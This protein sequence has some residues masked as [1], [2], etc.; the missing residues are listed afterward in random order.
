MKYFKTVQK[1]TDVM[2]FG[3]TRLHE[4]DNIPNQ[5]GYHPFEHVD[6]KTELGGVGFYIAE[7]IDYFVRNDLSME[8]DRVEDLWIEID[9]SKNIENLPK[10]SSEKYVIGNIYRHPGS[11]YK[12][13]CEKLCN[14]LETLNKSKTKYI[15]LGDYNIDMLKYNLATNVSNYANSLNSVGCNIHVDKPTRVEKN[16]AT[17]IDHVYSNLSPDRLSNRIVMS[18]ASDHFGILTKIPDVNMPNEKNKIFYRRSKLSSKQWEQLNTELKS[19]LRQKFGQ[20]ITLNPNYAADCIT[21]TYHSLIEKYMPIKT[22]SRKQRRFF[23]KPWITKGIKI[24]I[25]TKNKMFKMSKTSSEPNLVEKYKVYRSILTRLKT[26]AKNNYYAALAIEYGNDRSKIWRLVKEIT[27]RKKIT[28]SSIKAVTDKDGNKLHDQKLIAD[29]LNEHFS[30]IGEKMASEFET[31]ANSKNPLDY[32]TAEVKNHFTPLPTNI[33]EILKLILK[34]NDKKASGYDCI[35]NMILKNTCNVIAPYIVE[36]FNTCMTDGVFPNCFKKAQVVPLFKGG[37]KTDRNCYRPISLLPALGKLLEKVISIRTTEFLVKNDVLSKHQFGFREGY[38]TEYAVLDIYEKLLSNL[39]KGLSSCAIFLDL[40]KAF[41]SVDHEIL[42][43]KL[44][45]YGIRGNI[46]NFFRS[47]LSS[48]SQF[49]KIGK[50]ESSILPIKYGVP[51]GSILGPLLFLLFIND[52]PNATKFFIK[53]FADDTFLCA[54]NAEVDLLEAEVN[55]ELRNVNQWLVANKLTLNV[56]KSKFMIVT[57]KKLKS[58]KPSFMI[59]GK[60]IE[61]CDHYKYLGVF[62]DKNLSWK[63]HIEYISKK[64]SKACGSLANLR[65]CINIDLL[66]EVYH[67]LIHSYLRYGILV[68]GNASETNLQPLKCLINRAVRIMTFTPFGR[69]D[70]APLYECLKILDVDQVN[71]LETSKFLY[72]LKTNIL[73]TK[74]GNYFEVMGSASNHNYLLR[75]RERPASRITP[76][77]VSGQNSIQYRGEKIWDEI[78]LD[79]RNCDSLKKFKRV[80]KLKLLESGT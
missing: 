49:V 53:L 12:L 68:W 73:P 61:E 31:G 4:N 32:I 78:P 8:M 37:T 30:T 80:L 76:R 16:A 36:L 27:K 60:K 56:G 23:N 59:S 50:I 42:L 54:Q 44:P 2:A 48:R 45:K 79:I 77:L 25:R 63:Q 70:L 65:Y 10:P 75:N 18:D 6:S 22:L 74:I 62:I 55:R 34:L 21:I 40:A 47:Y 66:R 24:S 41:D 69:I 43:N 71:Y 7:E 9:I 38:S 51:Q 35:S 20:G 72:K 57:N 11:Q 19:V 26:K 39:D 28:N 5:E 13:F 33:S 52:L 64:I 1:K 17:C 58:Y 3:E 67:S 46:L 14:I 15:L 29:S